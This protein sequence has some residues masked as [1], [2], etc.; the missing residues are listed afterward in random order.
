M[1]TASSD[2]LARAAAAQRFDA[3]LLALA[4]PWVADDTAPQRIL[5]AR[6]TRYLGELLTFVREPAVPPDNNAAERSLRHLV[7]S[8][9]ISGGSRSPDG[10][11]TKMALTTLF[12]TWHAQRINPYLACRQ[13]LSPQV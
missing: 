6:I 9:K 10:T 11:D 2:R 13:L 1:D 4:Q 12:G 3:R 7:T 5:S 8:R